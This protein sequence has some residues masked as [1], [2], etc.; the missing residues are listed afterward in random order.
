MRMLLYIFLFMTLLF[1]SCGAIRI[2]TIYDAKRL[3]AQKLTVKNQK[4]ILKKSGKSLPEES[5]WMPEKYR[6]KYKTIDQLMKASNTT[7]FIVL[8][9]GKIYYENYFNGIQAGDL[10]QV[11]SVTKTLVTSLLKVAIQEGKIK[12]IHQPVSDFIPNFKEGELGKITLQHLAQMESG[13]KYDE[14]RKVVQTLL[15][16]NSKDI[17]SRLLHP[18]MKYEPGTVFKYKSI[19]TQLLG[20]CIEIAVGKSFME[21]ANEKIF[22]Q[23]GLQDS[24]LWT[25]DSKES[26]KLK[27]YGGLNIS[28]RDLVKF[29][30]LFANEKILNNQINSTILK[31][32][33]EN[34]CRS[35]NDGEYCNGWWYD[36]WSDDAHVFYGAGFKGQILM[37]NT[38]NNTVVLRLGKNKGGVKWYDMMKAL[39]MQV[40]REE[41]EISTD[42]YLF[43]IK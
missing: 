19:D 40:G 38:S 29:G 7:A 39:S 43:T 15:F 18:K 22:S 42:K 35:G 24:I 33:E 2:P 12:S 21:Y 16:Y 3:D 4:K 28:A 23:L 25:V 5:L 10:T 37:V 34:D 9:D 41:K 32:C 6:K 8:K 11:F 27:Y 17:S 30:N 36:E 31:P 26:E 13:L 14:Y 1:Q 20:E